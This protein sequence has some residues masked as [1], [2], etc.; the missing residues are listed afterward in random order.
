MLHSGMFSHHRLYNNKFTD[1]G[2]RALRAAAEERK[3]NPDFVE[4]GLLVQ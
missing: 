3:S 2:E 4:L 1:D